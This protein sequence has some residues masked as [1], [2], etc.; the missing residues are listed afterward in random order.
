M[1]YWV[2]EIQRRTLLETSIDNGDYMRL[3]GLLE[4]Y[5]KVMWTTRDLQR[6]ERLQNTTGKTVEL[7]YSDLD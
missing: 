6:K 4:T 3:Q 7:K 5:N 2:L 1:D